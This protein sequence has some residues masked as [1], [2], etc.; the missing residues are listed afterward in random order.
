MA[1]QLVSAVVA[2]ERAERDKLLLPTAP[3]EMQQRLR[4]APAEMLLQ[5]LPA[6]M[7]VMAAWAV[8]PSSRRLRIP[9]CSRP[10]TAAA[11][12]AAE[13]AVQAAKGAAKAA[14]VQA[15][16]AVAAAA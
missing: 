16:L 15:V 13:E 5:V 2:V 9:C 4:G 8:M 1:A 10:V 6:A 3:Q 7:A 12:G 11:G 14:G